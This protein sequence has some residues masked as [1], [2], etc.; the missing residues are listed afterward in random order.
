MPSSPSFWGVLALA[1][2]S[3]EVAALLGAVAASIAIGAFVGQTPASLTR[4]SEVAARWGATVGG[5][6]LG[7]VV[8]AVLVLYAVLS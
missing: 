5:L 6:V 1:S 3:T 4:G 7:C 8:L 2:I